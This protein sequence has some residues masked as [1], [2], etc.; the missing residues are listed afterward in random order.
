MF[1]LLMFTGLLGW[2]RQC[3]CKILRAPQVAESD[4]THTQ[5]FSS[6]THTQRTI[7][8][9]QLQ[10]S[11]LS[12]A[13]EFDLRTIFPQTKQLRGPNAYN[14]R[15]ARY[16]RIRKAKLSQHL[17]R[18]ARVPP[19]GLHSLGRGSCARCHTSIRIHGTDP[20]V[21]SHNFIWFV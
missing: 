8:E 16:N 14:L 4:R 12:Q 3:V 11:A 21:L 19:E 5:H 13:P 20:V 6:H 9:W 2:L 15:P 10:T 18:P 1:F 7:E 17:V